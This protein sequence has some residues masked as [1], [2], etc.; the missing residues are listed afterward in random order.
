MA[1]STLLCFGF[2]GSA[3][4]DESSS[5]NYKIN[6]VQIGGTGSDEEAC[7][8]GGNY[9]SR[10]SVGD[11]VVGSGKS[12]SYSAQFG[13]NTT[14][15]PLLEVIVQAGTNDMGELDTNKTGTASAVIK[16]RNYLSNGYVVQLAGEAPSQGTHRL[17]TMT[18][19]C[20][21]TSQPGAEQFGINLRENSSPEVGGNPVQ[22]PNSG[23]AFGAPGENYNT[24]NLFYFAASDIIAG[25]SISSGQ[26]E[27]TL[28]MVMNVSAATPGGR[29]NSSYAAVVVPVY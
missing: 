14:A 17:A 25:S 18:I 1:L 9:C 24:S 26:T 28:S 6:E 3:V 13:S 12:D 2:A 19:D 4:A 10:V 15:E 5:N 27:Y 22:V 23:F 29:Y 11:L 21:C 7:S 20:P 16:V 8:S